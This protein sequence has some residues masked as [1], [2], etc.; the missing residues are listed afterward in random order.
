MSHAFALSGTNLISFDTAT[1][2]TTTTIRHRQ[3]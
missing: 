1:P 3:A 2:T